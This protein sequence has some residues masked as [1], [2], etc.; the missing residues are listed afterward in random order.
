MSQFR[1]GSLGRLSSHEGG[2]PVY[3]RTVFTPESGRFVG[4]IVLSPPFELIARTYR[5]PGTKAPATWHANF[6]LFRCHGPEMSV[7]GTGMV[8]ATYPGSESP[9]LSSGSPCLPASTIPAS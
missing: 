4:G 2:I 1:E 8:E 3:C 7:P 5:E 6:I 9:T